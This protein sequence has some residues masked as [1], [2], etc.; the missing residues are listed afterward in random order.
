M[1]SIISKARI[2]KNFAEDRDYILSH[3][4][5]TRFLK[6][7]PSNSIDL[8]VTSPP[9]FMGKDYDKST[10][11]IDFISFHKELLPEIVRITK[12]GG[13]IC[14]QVG[15]HV[16]NGNIIP[17]D[18]LVHEIF[19]KCEDTFLRNR[20]IWTYGHGLHSKKRFS[21]R[22][23]VVLWYTKGTNYYFNL[24]RVR[25]PQKYPGKKHY[26]G[27]KK[28]K[29]SGNPL[30]KNPS[31]VWE[32]PNVKANHIE[33]TDHPCQF[34]VA[35]VQRLIRSL[36]PQ[37]ARIFDPFIGSGTTGVAAIIERRRFVGCE[38]NPK[39]LHIAIKR[40]LSAL[41]N[42]IKF[43]SVDKPI[44]EPNSNLSVAIKPPNFR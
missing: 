4:E 24:D 26:K 9:Y 17:L 6:V 19:N 36:T 14:W 39:Y 22:H 25:V 38:T 34:P 41:S 44:F 15:Y 29:F 18:F 3:Q 28:G 43:R 20:I 33:K 30:G 37:S 12:E 10:K 1:R 2:Y 8:T 32:I 31:D 11:V 16:K 42:Q 23:E 35:L 5:C 13:S 27:N 21:G 40:C 7:I